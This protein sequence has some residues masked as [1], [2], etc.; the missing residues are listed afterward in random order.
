MCFS[1]VKYGTTACGRACLVVGML[2]VQGPEA[3]SVCFHGV[4]AH[5]FRLS[6]FPFSMAR[7]HLLSALQL[8]WEGPGKWLVGT[9]FQRDALGLLAGEEDSPENRST[10]ECR[11]ERL[12]AGECVCRS[13]QMGE[14]HGAKEGGSRHV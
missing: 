11:C 10:W 9:A 5:P 4:V 7:L 1:S 13:E 12:W 2:S 14:R 6:P 3:H 8:P